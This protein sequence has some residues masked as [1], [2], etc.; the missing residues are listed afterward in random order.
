VFSFEAILFEKLELVDWKQYCDL[1]TKAYEDAPENDPEA[2]ASYTALR[3]STNKF[4]KMIGSKVKVEFVDGDPYTSAEQMREEVKKT[5][6]MKVMKDF[7]DHPFFTEEENWRFRAVHDWFS[8]IISGQP[9][10][11]KGELQAYNTHI[12]MMPP[13]AWPALFTEIIGQ[14][15]YQSTKGSFPTQKVAILKGFDYKNIGKVDG[16]VIQNKTLTKA[17]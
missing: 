13:A 11:Q 6:I 7:S 10:T 5:K 17:G 2:I 9:F 14:V 4:F 16:Y 12:K 1:V 3:D 15:C 8:H